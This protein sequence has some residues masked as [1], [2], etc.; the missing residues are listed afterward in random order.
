MIGVIPCGDGHAV[1]F[2]EDR[3]IT[4]IPP[5]GRSGGFL[6]QPLHEVD[7]SDLRFTLLS[8]LVAQALNG[9]A[10]E[11]AYFSTGPSGL[12]RLFDS[13]LDLKGVELGD[14]RTPNEVLFSPPPGPSWASPNTIR[15]DENDVLVLEPGR[16]LM[17]AAFIETES[18]SIVVREITPAAGESS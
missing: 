6:A 4:W 8:P 12:M 2:G 14:S 15:I 5:L 7:E 13:V 9:P 3:K 1:V 11:K 18:M 17:R 16:Y 10:A